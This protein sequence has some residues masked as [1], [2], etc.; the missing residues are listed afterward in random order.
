MHSH[1]N[2]EMLLG[3]LTAARRNRYFYGKRMDVQH[4]Q[5][6]QDYGKLK[7]WMINR[8][9]LGMGVLCGLQVSVE[10]DR[11][12]VEPGVAIDALGREIVVPVRTSIAPVLKDQD[13][14]GGGGGNAETPDGIYTLWLCYHECL[15]DRQP[16]MASTCGTRDEC[17]PAT[18]VETFC[19]KFEAGTPPL[20]TD[21]EWC[22]DLWPKKPQKP[23][24]NDQSVAQPVRS[25]ADEQ[26]LREAHRSRRHILCKLFEETCAPHTDNPC[27]P[28]ALVMLRDGRIAA[29]SCIVRP[30]IYSN[31]QLLDL[32]LCLAEKIED[33][34]GKKPTTLLQVQSVDFL[35]LTPGA[36][37]AVVAS[38]AS[39]LE[40]TE[41]DIGGQPNAI[42]VRFNKP[43]ATDQHAPTT[44]AAGDANYE[45][46]NVQILANDQLD[47]LPYVPGNLT[48]EAA[49]TIRFDLDPESPYR[50]SG[51]GWQKGRYRIYL[52]GDESLPNHRQALAD[53]DGVALDGE[54]KAPAGGV[55]SGNGSAGGDFNA[56][57]V[58]GAGPSAQLMH[59]AS[60]EFFAY[61]AAGAERSV[62]AI[63]TPLK[64]S[65]LKAGFSHFRIKFDQPYSLDESH[66]PSTPGPDVSSYE[67]HNVQVLLAPEY[68]SELGMPYLPGQ[69]TFEAPDTLRFDVVPGNRV[70]GEGGRWFP[71][72]ITLRLFLRGTPVEEM[73][74]RELV[75]LNGVSLD[76]EPRA[77]A[78][79]LISGDG[80]AGGDFLAE[81]NVVNES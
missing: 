75:D 73:G 78:G 1:D 33:C 32:I 8:L 68:A 46:H 2:A 36:G 48:L 66:I 74:W 60:V 45:L 37:E 43:L 7:Q 14:C 80:T 29:D 47:G 41:V 34:C 59:V 22:A 76:G 24:P 16:V 62:G 5:M 71:P 49:D 69:L 21:P 20:Q 53:T 61:D 42:R 18:I 30:H 11:L 56:E 3:V 25:R 51:G 64:R 54:A 67:H 28:L 15:T 6:E 44:P 57:F 77:P 9:T 55:I 17:A 10:D 72:K 31:Q 19:L 27:V 58:I 63:K 52:R 35:R 40:I 12:Y 81:F 79:G 70:V 23:T 26:S 39:P 4:F 13:C 38:I 65:T 50:R